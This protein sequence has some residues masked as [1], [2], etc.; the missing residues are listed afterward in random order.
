[1]LDGKNV[2]LVVYND[3]GRSDI[4]FDSPD[5]EVTLVSAQGDRFVA[6]APK[7]LVAEAVLDE[8]ERLLADG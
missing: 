2:D 3:V 8:I 1:M 5:N 4:G 6:R 7:P